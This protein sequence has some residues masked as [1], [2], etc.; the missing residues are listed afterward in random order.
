MS[1][2]PEENWKELCE[3]ERKEH[4]D[5]DAKRFA[6]HDDQICF[7]VSEEFKKGYEA[8]KSFY[9]DTSRTRGDSLVIEMIFN[10]KKTKELIEAR[11]KIKDLI[12]E[13]EFYSK[14]MHEVETHWLTRCV[15]FTQ[16]FNNRIKY[17][18][19]DIYY[20]VRHLIRAILPAK[21][22]Y[23][24]ECRSTLYQTLQ[25]HLKETKDE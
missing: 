14:A 18:L 22:G 7:Q 20:G 3:K 2:T 16:T 9:G 12:A 4:K 6:K 11:Q 25:A 23:E 24:R 10:K 5:S 1:K 8:A 13:A 17:K 21:K 19:R 15:R